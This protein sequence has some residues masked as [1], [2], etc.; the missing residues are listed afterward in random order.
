MGKDSLKASSLLHA[1]GRPMVMLGGF[2]YEQHTTGDI[3]SE[4]K[5]VDGE[6]V[7]LLYKRVLGKN[8]QAF[9]IE[10]KDAHEFVLSNGNPSKKLLMDL[11]HQ[12][13]KALNSEHDK[14]T[15]FRLIGIIADGMPILIGMPPEPKAQEVANRPTSGTDELVLKDRRSGQILLETQV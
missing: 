4:Y 13:A 10:L 8:T 1:S 14:A 5:W 7:M 15:I 2:V 11:C 3:V 9:M 12:A 6:P